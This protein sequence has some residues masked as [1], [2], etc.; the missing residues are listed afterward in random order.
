MNRRL[1]PANAYDRAVGRLRW[2]RWLRAAIQ[3]LPGGKRVTGIVHWLLDPLHRQ[4]WHLARMDHPD[5][6]QVSNMTARRRYPLLYQ[7]LA[8]QLGGHPGPDI[9]SFGCSTG[10]EAADLLAYLPQARVLG[11]DINPV[12]I[13]TARRRHRDARLRFAVAGTPAGLAPESLDAVLCLAVLQRGTLNNEVPADA[14]SI[15]PFA[16][17]ARMLAELD[18]CLRPGGLLLID[19]TN[20]R[21]TDMPMADRYEPVLCK[22]GGGTTPKYGPDSRLLPNARYPTVIFRKKPSAVT[23]P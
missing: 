19:H 8:D 22:L 23:G 9:L 12:A 5:L 6:L 20:Y 1:E 17:V 16:R 13:R 11:L 7:A 10:E 3:R 2:L 15:L 4:A 18:R 21:F 14:G